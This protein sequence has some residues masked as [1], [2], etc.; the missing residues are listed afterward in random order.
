[1]LCDK[2]CRS[3]LPFSIFQSILFFLGIFAIIR[4]YLKAKDPYKK[5][6]LLVSLA[7]LFSLLAIFSLLAYQ[8][9]PRFFLMATVPFLV[10][11]GM[12]LKF[13]LEFF[14]QKEKIIFLL[15]TA[16]ILFFNLKNNWNYF[17]ERKFLEEKPIPLTGTSFMDDEGITLFSLEKIAN[18]IA[19][20]KGNGEIRIAADNR[21][22]RSVFYLLQY[23]K[24]IPA[25]Y[26][27]LSGFE[28][29]GAKDYFLI[30]KKDSSRNFPE[31]FSDRFSVSWEGEFERLV[32]Y[33]LDGK[34]EK[35]EV[36]ESE[37]GICYDF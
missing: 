7:W 30:A 15:A 3:Q 1:M 29:T 27:K 8:I 10:M 11:I 32:V 23:Q 16:I 36:F 21:Y 37:E 28:P 34:G 5:G 13:L 20:E 26:M 9:S 14:P 4:D 22:A 2:E 18:Y 6:F 19:E 17:S 33:R 24:H 25:C 35:T 31:E 12:T